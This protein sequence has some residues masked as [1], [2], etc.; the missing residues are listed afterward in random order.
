MALFMN[1]SPAAEKTWKDLG[2]QYLFYHKS[3]HDWLTRVNKVCRGHGKNS[4]LPFD[5]EMFLDLERFAQA[6]RKEVP[7]HIRISIYDIAAIAFKD[8]KGRFELKCVEG[9][10]EG[11][12]KNLRFWPFK[13]RAV[14]GHSGRAL[15][16]RSIFHGATKMYYLPGAIS[17][18]RKVLVG[19]STA[20]SNPPK[21]LFHRAT[22]SA[23]K[24]ILNNLEGRL[25]PWFKSAEGWFRQGACL[26]FRQ[27]PQW[28]RI[29]GRGTSQ[30]PHWTHHQLP[31]RFGGRCRFLSRHIGCHF[32]STPTQHI[33]SVVDTQKN[34][35]L[36]TRKEAAGT[37]SLTGEPGEGAAS[38]SAASVTGE[39]ATE[40]A[41][42]MQSKSKQPPA[43]PPSKRMLETGQKP[44]EPGHPPPATK[45][46]RVMMTDAPKGMK[47]NI[48]TDEC[49]LCGTIVV[50]GQKQCDL[51]GNDQEMSLADHVPELIKD[52]EYKGG[53]AEEWKRS[54]KARRKE[55]LLKMGVRSDA[56]NEMLT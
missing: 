4:L 21:L 7:T 6:F 49:A 29:S 9:L 46:R 23:W 41:S 3:L 40:S 8:A 15:A 19:P 42:V 27:I 17:T 24:S 53:G 52:P 34:Q 47:F 11:G 43:P 39:P 44:P 35:V 32:D 28:Q 38:S 37:A 33:I 22:P 10:P 48:L 25:A 55:A 13:I 18:D 54:L 31:K 2:C 30:V 51:C 26:L 14:Q 45:A 16:D 1:L 12:P 36:W 50:S 20:D 56:R 5:H